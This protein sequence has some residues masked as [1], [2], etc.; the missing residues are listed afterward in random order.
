VQDHRTIREI[1]P[2][3]FGLKAL[4][5]KENL[6]LLYRRLKGHLHS[7]AT[8]K[9]CWVSRQ[10]YENFFKFTFIRNPW[11]RVFSWY[12]NV[13]RDSVLQRDFGVPLD[14]SFQ[15][16]VRRHL[17]QEA[18][19]PQLF[20]LLNHAG[21]IPLN[22]IGRFERL[23]KDFNHVCDIL[24][25]EDKSLPELNMGDGRSY[26][27][28]YDAESIDIVAERYRGEIEYFDFWFGE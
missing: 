9:K 27:G 12:S 13:M 11:S 8:G 19:R 22:F 17:N 14:C 5:R 6:R 4:N 2:L 16:F 28:Y 20:W 23:E 7:R 21:R 18:L 10:Q 25:F 15:Q 1:E 3:V 24:G 26:V